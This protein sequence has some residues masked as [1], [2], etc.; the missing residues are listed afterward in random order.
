MSQAAAR[1][2]LLQGGSGAADRA[3]VLYRIRSRWGEAAAQKV[4][5]RVEAATDQE[6]ECWLR[7][8]AYFLDLPSML[9]L[10]CRLPVSQLGI[11]DLLDLLA[12]DARP[13]LDLVLVRFSALDPQGWHQAAGA[14]P[15]LEDLPDPRRATR[16][17]YAQ[18]WLLIGCGQEEQGLALW[19]SVHRRR[20]ILANRYEVFQSVR[21]GTET[22]C[23]GCGRT[24]APHGKETR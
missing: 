3:E 5:Y 10:E 23:S 4:R 7:R 8:S 2:R 18:G 21:Q 20:G 12:A 6:A 14:V 13:F 15:W 22:S 16:H 1:F 19:Q 9:D 11:R 24:G 17:L